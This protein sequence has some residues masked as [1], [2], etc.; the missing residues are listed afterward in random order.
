MTMVLDTTVLIDVL[1]GEPSASVW[2]LG[3]EV[4]PSC[5][6][7]TR[8]EI[9]CG[10]RSNERALAERLFAGLTWVSVSESIARDAGE[11]GRKFRRSHTGVGPNDLI[12]AATA[13]D[14]GAELATSNLKH[15]PM[16]RG[17]KRPY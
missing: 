7:I 16:F 2:L 10:L 14:Q 3:L 4:Q 13:I 15:F 6:E 9:L 12:I 17:L 11:L 8:V 5:S 1:R